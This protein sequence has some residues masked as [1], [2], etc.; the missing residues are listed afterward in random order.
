MK[1]ATSA[2]NEHD[3]DSSWQ[4][5]ALDFFKLNP[6][7]YVPSEQ[8]FQWERS[9]KA[10]T[11]SIFPRQVSKPWVDSQIALPAYLQRIHFCR[12]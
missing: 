6:P 3:L 10:G 2:N 9:F 4:I 11:F 8:P 1:W 5:G 12:S 7:G